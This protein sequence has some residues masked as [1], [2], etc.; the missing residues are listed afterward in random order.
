MEIKRCKKSAFSV[1]GKEGS[2][3]AGAGFIQQLWAEANAHFEE[4]RALAKRDEKGDFVGFWGAMTDFSRSFQP[5]DDFARGLY[6]A[7]VECEDSAEAPEGWQKW[8][9]PAFEYLYVHCESDHTF[10]EVTRYMNENGIKLAGAVHD[11]TCPQTGQNYLFF[12]I[13][14]L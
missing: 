9:I 8:R 10:S 7:G 14:R 12:P 13:A 3:A 11:F 5:W 2:T 4:V 6:L 1:I